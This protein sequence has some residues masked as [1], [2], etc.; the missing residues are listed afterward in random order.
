[1]KSPNHHTLDLFGT[2]PFEPQPLASGAWLLPQFA[3]AQAADLV[4]AVDQIALQSPFRHMVTRGGFRMSVAMTNCG[5]LGWTSD[6]RGYRYASLDVLSGKPWPPM[7]GVFLELANA[8][9]NAG[10]F[11]TLVPD[12]CLINKYVRGARMSLH[13]DRDESDFSAPIVSVSLGLPAIF[14]FGGDTRTDKPQRVPLQ[15]GDVVV[16]GGDARLRYHGVLPLKQGLHPLTG[17]HRI[18]LTFRRAG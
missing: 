12:A 15:H 9:A 13:Q 10:G 5:A 17:A 8:A 4:T 1:L 16:W 14:L 2:R 6:R 7:P 3:A 18:N 11:N